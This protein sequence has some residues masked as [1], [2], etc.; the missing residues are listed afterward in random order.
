MFI[1]SCYYYI[2]HD[3]VEFLKH[4]PVEMMQAIGSTTPYNNSHDIR[5]SKD[6]NP[7]YKNDPFF[8]LK[9]LNE[10]NQ[11]DEEQKPLKFH[12]D[13][14]NLNRSN[15]DPD[16]FTI[17]RNVQAQI[18]WENGEWFI[19]NKSQLLTTFMVINKK[20]KISKGDMIVLGNKKFQFE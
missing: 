3:R 4:H 10:T 17:T 16:N 12:G 9:P 6:T 18:S 5:V 20:I 8:V 13:L 15:V 1:N 14:T 11:I 2:H 19:E 7:V